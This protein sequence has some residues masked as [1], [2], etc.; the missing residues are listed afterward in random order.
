MMSYQKIAGTMGIVAG[1]GIAATAAVAQTLDCTAFKPQ[2]NGRWS[3]T[4]EVTITGPGGTATIGPEMRIA[5]NAI[6]AG[7][8]VVELLEKQ[9]RGAP[10]KGR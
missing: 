9:C 2:P 5:P 6:F 7:L 10:P 3:P 4:R 1:I 8:P